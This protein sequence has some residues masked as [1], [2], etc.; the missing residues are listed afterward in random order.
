ML[1]RAERI[2]WMWYKLSILSLQKNNLQ[3]LKLC[4]VSF[5]IICQLLLFTLL[6]L[7]YCLTF[8]QFCSI[9]I[10]IFYDLLART[11]ILPICVILSNFL[12][13]FFWKIL[14]W[15]L[16]FELSQQ[17]SKLYFLPFDDCFYF[18]FIVC[19]PDVYKTQFIPA[20]GQIGKINWGQLFLLYTSLLRLVS[21]FSQIVRYYSPWL[22]SDFCFSL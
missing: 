7:F 2:I 15:Y 20:Q 12:W 10:L 5:I 11:D 17:F 4:T 22:S 21:L 8:A 19:S 1:D 9:F 16:C 6:F 18:T 13:C 3:P 14:S